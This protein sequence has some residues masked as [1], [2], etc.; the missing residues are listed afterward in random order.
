MAWT[1]PMTA[2]ANTAF[3]AAQFNQHVRDN[4]LETAVAKAT[5][6]GQIFVSTGA[7]AL[8][9]RTV[10]SHSVNVAQSTT[11]SSYTDLSTVGPQVTVTTG[12]RAIVFF[13]A[14]IQNS[15]ANA[16]TRCAVEVSGASSIAASDSEDLYM[17][18]LPA[19][20]QFRSAAFTTFTT[21]TPGSNTFTVKYKINSGTGTFTDRQMLVIPL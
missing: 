14:Q 4:L 1:A 12:T 8:A 18:G 2:V 11:S 13:E 21:L 20:Q 19:S 17:D 7:N 5:A 9:A 16:A 10:G 15:L 3:T 6:A